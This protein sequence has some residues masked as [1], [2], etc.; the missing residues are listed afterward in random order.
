M[1]VKV[2]YL[3]QL[4]PAFT[5][6][7]FNFLPGFCHP[8]RVRR[9]QTEADW[10]RED[11]QVPEG[12]FRRVIDHGRARVKAWGH[13]EAVEH[14]AAWEEVGGEQRQDEVRQP[15]GHH[16]WGD[17]VLEVA[18]LQV[19]TWEGVVQGDDQKCFNAFKRRKCQDIFCYL[20]SRNVLQLLCLILTY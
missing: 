14:G 4:L 18:V 5:H 11:V 3:G 10:L 7:M 1:K 15:R 9:P 12:H 8:E 13:E 2:S 20:K 16:E 17:R 6:C 19:Q